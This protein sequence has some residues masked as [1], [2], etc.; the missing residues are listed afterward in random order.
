MLLETQL[1]K[2]GVCIHGK[3]L[4]R[5]AIGKQRDCN[6]DQSSHEV[7]VAIAAVVQDFLA[8]GVRFRLAV[9][10]ELADAA[11]HFGE[12]VAR[13]LAQRLEGVSEL[14]DITIPILPVVEG[15]KIFAY[16]VNRRQG[17]RLPR[18]VV[19]SLYMG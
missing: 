9:Q 14:D 2:G 11:A 19:H 4:L 3:D 13:L 8:S 1:A 5:R 18:C 15:S 6:G 7:G 12:V 17:M 10:P 16:A